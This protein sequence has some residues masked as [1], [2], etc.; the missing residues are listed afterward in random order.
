MHKVMAQDIIMTPRKSV[1]F[2]V[3][4]KIQEFYLNPTE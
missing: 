1:L 2:E 3:E 4:K